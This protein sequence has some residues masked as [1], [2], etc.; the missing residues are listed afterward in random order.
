MTDQPPARVEQRHIDRATSAVVE[1]DMVPMS[2]ETHNLLIVSVAAA[3]AEAEAG[4]Q[5]VCRW[6]YDS[7]FDEWVSGCGG[8][9]IV[10]PDGDF[11]QGA[12]ACLFC[13]GRL[14]VE[15]EKT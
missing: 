1:I 10:F 6:K 2:K 12:T 14:I 15:E 13:G 5:K 11:P 8:K 3:L 4:G 9:R 7:D